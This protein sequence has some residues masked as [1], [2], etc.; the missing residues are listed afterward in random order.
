VNI[1]HV[2]L[3]WKKRRSE[4]ERPKC[5]G[6]GQRWAQENLQAGYFSIFNTNIRYNIIELPRWVLILIFPMILILRL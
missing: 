4:E 1:E 2:F 5:A 6:D 3:A